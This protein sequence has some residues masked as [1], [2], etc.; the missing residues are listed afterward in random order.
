MG[1]ETGPRPAWLME[2]DT[3][4][5]RELQGPHGAMSCS[6]LRSCLSRLGL[7]CSLPLCVCMRPKSRQSCPT[8]CDL[9]DLSLPSSSVHGILQA[10]ILEWVAISFSRGSS[11]PRDQTRISCGSC[12][13]GGFWPLSPWGEPSLLPPP[14]FCL[15]PC[16]LPLVLLSLL[17][18]PALLSGPP[19]SLLASL[20]CLV[21]GE[22]PLFR[23]ISSHWALG[24]PCVCVCVCVSEGA[25]G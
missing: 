21:Q 10:R 4:S 20:C 14:T 19:V 22:S 24:D 1:E 8:L 2:E 16:F 9:M 7:C 12:T 11:R 13:V 5:P 18:P 3:A 15:S 6:V 25:S 23:N 17:W